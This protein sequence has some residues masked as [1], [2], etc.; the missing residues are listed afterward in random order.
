M[1]VCL[2]LFFFSTSLLQGRSE[3]LLF[4]NNSLLHIHTETYIQSWMLLS[5]V[6]DS[7]WSFSSSTGAVYGFGGVFRREL[8]SWVLPW[9]YFCFFPTLTKL[10]PYRRHLFSKPQ[11]VLCIVSTLWHFFITTSKHWR[12][13]KTWS[14]FVSQLISLWASIILRCPVLCFACTWVYHH[15][16]LSSDFLM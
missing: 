16:K 5:A 1:C 4:S 9:D 13:K 14:L 15:K 3:Y 12:K 11:Y 2:T 6:T 8:I 7:S 10:L